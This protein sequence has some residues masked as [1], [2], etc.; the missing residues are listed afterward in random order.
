MP[1]PEI[2]K[3]GATL[4]LKICLLNFRKELK[5]SKS[6]HRQLSTRKEKRSHVFSIC[7]LL[8]RL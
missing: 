8:L 5:I 6:D 7:Q 3:E 2:A 1:A 4:T